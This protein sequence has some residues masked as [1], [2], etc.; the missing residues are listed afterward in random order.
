VDE[1]ELRLE[2][3]A[4]AG[5][6]FAAALLAR[7][8]RPLTAPFPAALAPPGRRRELRL[9]WLATAGWPRAPR[10][11]AWPVGVAS[12][13]VEGGEQRWGPKEESSESRMWLVVELGCRLSAGEAPEVDRMELE[14][15]GCGSRLLLPP[16]WVDFGAPLAVREPLADSCWCEFAQNW[17]SCGLAAA[18]PLPPPPMML[19]MSE[20][21]ARRVWGA[22]RAALRPSGAP[23]EVV[24]WTCCCCCLARL[25][26][27]ARLFWN[28][29]W[30]RAASSF[31]SLASSSRL[32]TSG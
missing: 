16:L 21:W 25:R 10:P 1:G 19:W 27:L 28:Q 30:M 13:G 5:S 6:E 29:T 31:V 3:A 9:G 26:N 18:L 8:A 17:C 4:L 23:A 32:C 20:W 14:L 2:G 24:E 12:G 15:S 22:P 11:S 7:L